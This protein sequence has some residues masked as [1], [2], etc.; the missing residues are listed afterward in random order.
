MENNIN[1]VHRE[2]CPLCNSQEIQIVF[3]RPFSDPSIW[4]LR[5]ILT[6]GEAKFRAD[7]DWATNWGGGDFPSGTGTLNGPNIPV[8]KGLYRVDFNP[9][10]G[11]YSF[12][13]A[14]IGIIGDATP[15]GWDSDTDLTA[16]ASDPALFTLNNFTLTTASAKFRANDDWYFNWGADTFPTGTAVQD[17]A[18]I[19]TQA[20]TYNI[21]FNVNT[22]EYSFN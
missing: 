5:I 12:T 16:D 1:F 2:P 9:T 14:T 15:T 4:K 17:G 21:T 11:V 10:T 3:S 20:G 13:A 6:D 8:T 18:N 22:G 19:P 7:N